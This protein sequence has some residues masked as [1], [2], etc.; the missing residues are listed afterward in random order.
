MAR[1]TKVQRAVS[2][3]DD[4]LMTAKEYFSDR[5]HGPRPR[6]EQELSLAAWNGIRSVIHGKLDNEWFACEFPSRDC[7]DDSSRITG[8]NVGMFSERLRAELPGLEWPL[9]ADKRPGTL[10]IL[11]LIEFCWQYIA[12]PAHQVYHKFMDHWHLVSFSEEEGREEFQEQVNRILARNGVAYELCDDGC[13][14]RL[15]P[16]EFGEAFLNAQFNTGDNE[17][18]GLLEAARTKYLDPDLAVQREALE[19]LWDAWERLKTIEPG[20]DKKA[21]VTALLRRASAEANF[22]HALDRE[23]RELTDIGNQFR[24]RHSETSQVP[25]ENGEH[26]D[27][28]FERMFAM[29]RLL[30]RMTSRGG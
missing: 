7:G 23:A 25:L 4:D 29:I 1:L 28:L 10:E 20:R 2:N 15:V 14:R 17:L 18:N 26:V 24:I 5:E 6:Q 19:K 27:Y 30:L 11:D 22:R 13:V 3:Q 16:D 21:S 12:K 9:P 8:S